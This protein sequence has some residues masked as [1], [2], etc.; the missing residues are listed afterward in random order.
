MLESGETRADTRNTI[1]L[2]VDKSVFPAGGPQEIRL[3]AEWQ[4]GDI[5][6]N[7]PYYDVSFQSLSL[8][9]TVDF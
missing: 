2:K 5:N 8:G 4:Y 3:K 9:A 7:D 6:S 1:A